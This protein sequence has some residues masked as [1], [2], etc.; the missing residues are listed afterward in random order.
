MPTFRRAAAVIALA[1]VVTPFAV[2]QGG[3]GGK[4]PD[5]TED[6]EGEPAAVKVN[7]GAVPKAVNDAIA[8]YAEKSAKEAADLTAELGGDFNAAQS[9]TIALRAEEPLDRIKE[10]V[11]LSETMLAELCADLQVDP[12]KDLWAAKLGPMNFYYFKSKASFNDAYPFLT[13]RFPS[14][15]LASQ[16]QRILDTGRFIREMPSPLAGGEVLDYEYQLAHVIGQ[17]A[18]FFTVRAAGIASAQSKEDGEIL[19]AESLSWLME[20]CA[21]YSSVRFLGSNRT[22]CVSDSKYVGNIA[23]ADK[24]LDSAYRL[25]CVEM[26]DG[27]EKSKDFALL[28]RTET[29]ALDYRDLAKS[30]SYFDWMMRDENRPKLIAILKGMRQGSFEASLKKNGGMSLADLESAWKKFVLDDYSGKKPAP[31]VTGKD[32]AKPK[33]PPAKKDA[34]PKS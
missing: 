2:A 30:W 32:K 29:N 5:P 14:H 24:D 16:K 26:A 23:M 21:M 4:R 15:K 22:Y 6:G 3:K 1:L 12:V 33:A 20:G 17:T 9:L 18:L 11:Q 10:L 28:N 34:K 25:V 7:V 27:E 31:V 8:K 19:Q 13:K